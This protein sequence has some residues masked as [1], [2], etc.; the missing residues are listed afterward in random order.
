MRH[1]LLRTDRTGLSDY[2]RGEPDHEAQE[3]RPPPSHRTRSVVGSREGSGRRRSPRRGHTGVIVAD[4]DE[5][6][7]RRL[8]V[9]DLP[10]DHPARTRE[11]YIVGWDWS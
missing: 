3:P 8:H 1:V 4:V 5:A 7:R 10:Y 6:E 2:W 11:S 9:E